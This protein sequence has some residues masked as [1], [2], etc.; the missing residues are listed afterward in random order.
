M[1]GMKR[2]AV[3]LLLALGMVLSV[4]SGGCS[5]RSEWASRGRWS[6]VT[7]VQNDA[8]AL[9]NE[10]LQKKQR[11]VSCKFVS[12]VSRG[13]NKFEGVAHLSDNTMRDIAVMIDP[14][15]NQLYIKWKV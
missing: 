1:G 3:G 11:K 10:Q 8:A 13:E 2:Q 15:A 12:L 7:D 5:N 4:A 14:N 6:T 9:A